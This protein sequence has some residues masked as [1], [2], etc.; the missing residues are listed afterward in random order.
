MDQE[1]YFTADLSEWIGGK[2]DN[3]LKYIS[4]TRVVVAQGKPF[5]RVNK[6]SFLQRARSLAKGVTSWGRSEVK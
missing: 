2:Y 4:S 5:W 6:Q 1:D 3:G